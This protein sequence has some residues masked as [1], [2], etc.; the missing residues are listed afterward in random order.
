MRA[1]AIESS[2]RSGA[3]TAPIKGLSE[4]FKWAYTISKWR[5]L[6]GMSTGSQ[7]V[8]LVWCNQGIM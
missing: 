8:P 2:A 1:I 6:T 7:T 3:V 4:Y 5:L